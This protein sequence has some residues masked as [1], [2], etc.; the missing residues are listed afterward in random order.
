[1]KNPQA[2]GQIPMGDPPKFFVPE[3]T[4]RFGRLRQAL[5][6]A[7]IEV[8]RSSYRSRTGPCSR[9]NM[10]SCPCAFMIPSISGSQV[11]CEK[12]LI[13]YTF[14]IPPLALPHSGHPTLRQ[15]S[16]FGPESPTDVARRLEPRSRRPATR[17]SGCY[18]SRGIAD[19]QRYR[20][21]C[22]RRLR[23]PAA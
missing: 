21:C 8:N 4:E 11:T 20:R 9:F 22:G 16:G 23:S 14:T 15:A 13:D 10:I 5:P 2:D 17:S 19:P 1:M 12:R 6:S 18:P 3:F 7:I